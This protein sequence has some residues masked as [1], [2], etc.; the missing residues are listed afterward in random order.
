MKKIVLSLIVIITLLATLPVHADNYSVKELIP[1]D[2]Q[3]S[4]HTSNFIY[5]GMYYNANKADADTTKRNT[6]IFR[7]IQNVSDEAKPLS[8]SI[9]LF[10][11]KRKNIGTIHICEGSLAVKQGVP[12]EIP[13]TKEFLGDGFKATDVKY[14]AVLSDNP[15]CRNRT[16]KDEYIGQKID[17][18]GMKKNNQLNTQEK[19]TISVYLVIGGALLAAFLYAFMFTNKYKNMDGEDVRQGYAYKNQELEQERQRELK[20]HPPKPPEKIQEKTDE[21][22]R[23]EQQ[24]ANSDKTNTDLHNMFK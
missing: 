4:V 22:L 7:E 3:T 21:V 12:Y 5:K 11:E 8:I 18:I 19:N 17:E 16:G 24:E 1:V 2:I 13:V 23:Q 9:A 15:T 10:D 20:L 6:I 14:I